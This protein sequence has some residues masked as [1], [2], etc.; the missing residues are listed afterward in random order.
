MKLV[1]AL[2]LN[3]LL[4]AWL[5]P[6]LRRQWQEAPAPVWRW[7][8]AMGLGLRLLVGGLGSIRLVKDADYMSSVA[9]LLTAQLWA[10]PVA[11]WQSFVGNELHFAGNA[12][13]YYGMSNT[14]FLVKVLAVLNLASGG[15]SWLNGLYLALGAFVGG[16]AA[17]RALAGAWPRWPVGVGLVAFL[18]WPSVIW[19]GSGVN[20]ETALL[21]TGAG[22]FALFITLIYGPQGPSSKQFGWKFWVRV[23]VMLALAVLHFK[24]RYFFAAPLLAL[25]GGLALLRGLQKAGLFRPRWAQVLLLL[26]WLWA[27]AWLASAFSV[28]FRSNKFTNQLALIYARHLRASTNRPHFEYP[29]LRPTPA[30]IAQHAPLAAFNALARPWLGETQGRLLYVVGALETSIL[31]VLLVVALASGWR[32]S[33]V[34]LPFALQLTLGL[35]CLILAVLLGL[36]TPNLGSLARYRT[37]MLPFLLLLLLPPLVEAVGLRKRLAA[38]L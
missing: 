35:H 5:L 19:F 36:S 10:N 21:A 26:G 37:V 3:G 34:Q 17:A 16:W 1:L 33:S 9:R 23:V 13:V 28:A 25:L 18:G 12:A 22:V 15:L 20:K 6:W 24:L 7:A 32:K 31:V 38:V 11:A 30:S 29:E 14:F 27:G 8:L 4:L 2:A